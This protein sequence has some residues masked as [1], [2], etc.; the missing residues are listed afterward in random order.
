MHLAIHQR[1]RITLSRRLV[2][3]LL[4]I[5]GTALA[6]ATAEAILWTAGFDRPQF[7]VRDP[8]RGKAGRPGAVARFST[9]GHALVH[10]NSLGFRDHEHAEEKPPGIFRLAVLGDSFTEALQVELE[11]T[12]WKLLEKSLSACHPKGAARVEVLNFG[13]SGYSTAQE[14]LTLRSHVLRFRPDAVLVAFFAGNDVAENVRTLEG[15]PTRPYFEFRD[16]RLVLDSRF[17][18]DLQAR[19]AWLHGIKTRVFAL[20]DHSRIL[21]LALDAYGQMTT[22]RQRQELAK[23]AAADAP[24]VLA[25]PAGRPGKKPETGLRLNAL[26]PPPDR[27]WEN[28]WQVTEA[29]LSAMAAETREHH[30]RLLVTSFPT[31]IQV[32]PD[33]GA[34]R[35]ETAARG[36]DFLYAERRL[37]T[38]AAAAEIPFL[39]VVD[40]MAAEAERTGTY[41]H[42]FPNTMP[43]YGH[44]NEAGHRLV[45][46]LLAPRLCDL[47]EASA[48]R[49]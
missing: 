15:D 18:D 28:A 1:G 48:D 34:R 37:A 17:R 26:I 12:W 23:A 32:L 43:G 9:E 25:P 10:F 27:N 8:E 5:A 20:A 21:Q 36:H 3:L 41:F 33:G 42:G 2:N 30:A 45:G 38:F 31:G 6:W 11:R 46:D 49:R 40:P 24:P 29:L 7:Y 35:A 47:F 13:V 39:P 16:G 14:L 22:R 44:F 19:P 4:V